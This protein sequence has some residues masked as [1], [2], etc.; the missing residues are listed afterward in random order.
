MT[1]APEPEQHP[2]TPVVHLSRRAAL[3][4]ER[5]AARGPQR[6]SKAA[7]V[8]KVAKPAKVAQAAQV[9]QAAKPAKPLVL[10]TTE[11]TGRRAAAARA[12][13]EHVDD[14]IQRVV[15]RPAPRATR[16]ATAP[17]ASRSARAGRITLTSAA[18]AIAM[19]A[20]S[21]MPAHA[22]AGTS[23]ATSTIAP[24]VR[25]Q[26][27][28]V[29]QAVTAAGS[30]RDGFTVGGGST[31]TTKTAGSSGTAGGAVSFGGAVRSPFP[32]PVQMSSGFGYRSAPC[33]ACS[34][35]HQGLDFTPGMGTPIG[36]VAA[37]KVRVSGTYF[38][39]GNAVIIDHVVD[40]RQVSTLYG[41]MIPGSSPLK[42]G[43]TV[44]AG[45]FIGL[46][47]SSGVSTGAH[48]HLEVLMDGVTPID[49]KAWLEARI[50]RSLTL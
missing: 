22:S 50:G 28:A 8:A 2:A 37:G 24:I 19:F 16:T 10:A 20:A 14:R 33:G 27:Y 48:L 25:T 39:Y 40:G 7:P 26:D 17:R 31:V 49:P 15:R 3:E 5:A 9:A 34:S 32:G 18:A 30:D 29:T 38:S 43:D 11:P 21:A 42:V 35:L 12:T 23:M 4:A 41:H 13:T 47:G 45:Q 36:A 1:T 46:V 6:R 44:A